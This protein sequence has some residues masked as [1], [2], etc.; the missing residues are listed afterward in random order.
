MFVPVRL[1]GTNRLTRDD[2]LLLAFDAVILSEIL[3][4]DV[5]FGKIICGD[6]HAKLKVK[7]LALANEVRKL[8]RKTAAQPAIPS[9]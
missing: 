2:K 1:V 8:T 7:T 9:T 4:R 6:Q 3:G 5:A